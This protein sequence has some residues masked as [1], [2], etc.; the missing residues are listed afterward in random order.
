MTK[1]IDACRNFAN[2]PKNE[3]LFSCI[4]VHKCPSREKIKGVKVDWACSTYCGERKGVGEESWKSH[5]E[6]IDVDGR[7]ILKWILQQ[8]DGI[9]W[10]HGNGPVGSLKCW[11]FL[12]SLRN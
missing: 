4:H 9:A 12:H 11:E 8:Y 7:T 10:K 2:A 6:D 1:L 5:M 3:N